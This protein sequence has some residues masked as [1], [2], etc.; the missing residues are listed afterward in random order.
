LLEKRSSLLRPNR[1]KEPLKALAAVAAVCAPALSSP[2]LAQ[3]A[4]SLPYSFVPKT[5]VFIGAGGSFNW[6]WFDQ[7]LQGVSGV[8]DVLIGPNLVA[9]GQAGGPPANFDR[10]DSGLAFDAE[11]GYVQRLGDGPWLG[12]IKFSYKYLNLASDDH[13]ISIPQEGSFT[14]TGGTPVTIPF[15]G[16]VPI[17]TSQIKIRNQLA[18][19]PYVGR[20]FGRFYLYAGGGPALFDIESEIIDAVGFAEIGGNTVSVTG[21][22]A[23]F[24][25]SD[26]VWGGAAQVGVDYYLA[27][28]WFL[29][30]NYTFAQSAEYKIKYSSP[31]TNQNGPLTSEGTANLFARQQVTSHSF[32]I[33][34]NKVF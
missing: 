4:K 12:G 10:D 33:T 5:G 25:S 1:E 29:D 27:P 30:A 22:P 32:G 34:L 15:M 11:L 20:S 14:T 31:F 26:W 16:F 6:D 8:T 18:L 24:S 13:N 23:N 9:D 2:A 17:R 21:E 3:D 7:S 28:T 19:I